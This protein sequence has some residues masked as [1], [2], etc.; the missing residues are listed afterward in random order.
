M[1]RDSAQQEGGLCLIHAQ[2]PPRIGAA[3]ILLSLPICWATTPGESRPLR[4]PGASRP[5]RHPG[6]SRGPG[7]T[8]SELIALDTGLRRYDAETG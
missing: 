2:S 6:A 8:G 3:L 7:A 4:Y 5:L 1:E